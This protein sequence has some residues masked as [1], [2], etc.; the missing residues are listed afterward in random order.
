MPKRLISSLIIAFILL[1]S[2]PSFALADR[3]YIGDE[4]PD[5]FAVGRQGKIEDAKATQLSTLP[6]VLENFD[7]DEL[8]WLRY[9]A[10]NYHF[11]TAP[12]VDQTFFTNKMEDAG[13]AVQDSMANIFFNLTKA[14]ALLA[15]NIILLVFDNFLT[16]GMF[17]SIGAIVGAITSYE[18]G[19]LF[20]L[21]LL[22]MMILLGVGIAT[23]LVR[24]Q[25]MRAFTSVLVAALCLACIT[26]Y[27]VN[28]DKIVPTTMNFVNQTTGMAL[29]ATSYMKDIPEDEAVEID[30][31]AGETTLLQQGLIETT[32][33]MWHIMVG[34]PWANGMFGSGNPNDLKLLPSEVAAINKD[35]NKAISFQL[36]GPDGLFDVDINWD[37]I[38]GKKQ[39]IPKDSYMDTIWLACSNEVKQ[40]MLQAITGTKERYESQN[41]AV[42][43]TAGQGIT[44]STFH[45]GIAILS[46]IPAI[47]FLLFA[48]M[49]GI[50]ILVAQFVLMF[51]LILLPFAL[52]MGVAGEKGIQTTMLYIRH[53]LGAAAT[54]IIYGFY[55]S[56]ILLFTVSLTRIPITENNFALSGT[57]ISIVLVFAVI[58][59]KRFFEG[60]MGLISFEPGHDYGSDT[61]RFIK[62]ALASSIFY[63][64]GRKT[65]KNTEGRETSANNPEPTYRQ[66]TSQQG[67]QQGTQR[68]SQQGTQ[69]DSQQERG[70]QQPQRQHNPAPPRPNFNE[71]AGI[72][73]EQAEDSIWTSD[74]PFGEPP[75]DD[76]I[77]LESKQPKPQQQSS[78]QPLESKP[79]TQPPK[80]QSSNT[81]IETPAQPQPP[82][83]PR[84]QGSPHKE[85]PTQQQQ[86]PKETPHYKPIKPINPNKVEQQ[87]PQSP[88]PPQQQPGQPDDHFW[89]PNQPSEK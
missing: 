78:Q 4:K 2:V 54:K 51:L 38:L 16:E 70:S 49:V 61:G 88:E 26:A 39:E 82:Q 17:K 44:S 14:A 84:P 68:E 56:F 25:L 35:I 11:R 67:P 28:V 62:T 64:I 60:V 83:Q 9:P 79:S 77:P 80:P 22:L 15:N 29:M 71:P 81:G 53:L 7:S 32:N 3:K 73:A 43:F 23:H 13:T 18:E 12:S 58:F 24:A 10:N 48:V 21:M 46:L 47:I 34:A 33:S 89:E 59:R 40:S 66:R 20:S 37:V 8:I 85:P 63:K 65:N 86:P 19:G 87:P 69:H 41:T 52:L 1:L 75:H 50:P 36:L 72:F 27:T 74:D 5:N 6:I 42:L 57:L 31:L 55:M 45:M 30:T 76:P